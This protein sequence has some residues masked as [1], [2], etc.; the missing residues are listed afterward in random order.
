MSYQ[1]LSLK[2]RPQ[3]FADLAGQDHV[4]KTL[5]NAFE[6]DRVSQAYVLTGPRGVGK[7]T[8]VFPTPRG[9]VKT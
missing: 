6:K 4:A 2:Y 5:V 3:T 9:P 1:I 7:T 8:T